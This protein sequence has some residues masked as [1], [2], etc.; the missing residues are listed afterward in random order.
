MVVCEPT[1]MYDSRDLDV[2][3]PDCRGCIRVDE[4]EVAIGGGA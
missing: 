3:R 2:R 4:A 1:R